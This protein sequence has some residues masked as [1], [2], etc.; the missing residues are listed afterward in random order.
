MAITVILGAIASAV[1]YRIGGSD[2]TWHGK[3]RDWGC[4]LAFMVVF[5]LVHGKFSY[6]TYL[7]SFLF[8]WVTLSTYWKKKGTDAQWYHWFLHGFMVGLSSIP[9]AWIGISTVLI[10][11]R[12]LVLG[13]SMMAVSELSTNVLVEEYGRGFLIVATLP[14]LFI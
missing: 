7:L 10:L 5:Y 2:N 9:L 1:L 14:I 12:S 8:C 4:S 13:L 3:E 11:I 6:L